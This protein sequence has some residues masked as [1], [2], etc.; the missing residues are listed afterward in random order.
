ML[1]FALAGSRGALMA[2]QAAA[3]TAAAAE[4]A[5]PLL[6]SALPARPRPPLHVARPPRP[7]GAAI[8]AAS[9]APSLP[10]MAARQPRPTVP[11]PFPGEGANA[12]LPAAPA[13]PPP[14][15][16][17]G[18]ALGA[19]RD[20]PPPRRSLDLAPARS[21]A[22]AVQAAPAFAS[23]PGAGARLHP[24]L[25][26]SFYARPGVGA[27]P[28]GPGLRNLG[29]SV[30][31][32]VGHCRFPALSRPFC[33]LTSAPSQC[34]LNAVLNLLSSLPPFGAALSALPAGCLA[35]GGVGD[36]LRA[37][38]AALDPARRPPGGSGAG[39]DALSDGPR[40]LQA[41]VLRCGAPFGR[42]TQEDAHELLL[43]LLGQTQAEVGA[44][45]GAPC[46]VT[47]WFGGA[48]ARTLVCE[49][50]GA[51][52]EAVAE[53]ILGLSLEVPEN[54]PRGRCD[55]PDLLRRALQ[56]E[57]RGVERRCEALAPQGAGAGAGAAGS[58]AAAPGAAPRCGGQRATLR[59]T[60][61][62]PPAALLLH[63]KRFTLRPAAPPRAGVVAS[64]S[65]VAVFSPPTLH[66]GPL[67]LLGAPSP[68]PPPHPVYDLVGVVSHTGPGAASG[69]YVCTVRGPGGAWA[70]HNDEAVTPVAGD[71][72]HNSWRAAQ[73]TYVLL[74]VRREGRGG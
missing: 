23:T 38:L 37:A 16:P 20:A 18:R 1:T 51:A 44:T 53:P 65:S 13:W 5:R 7:P 3:Q 8:A 4:H 42:G 19:G 63:L 34:Y 25:I 50:C 28:A 10:G 24:A 30:R 40:R 59:R 47:A 22:V 48:T 2:A 70:R 21:P 60:L 12:A 39:A 45:P 9:A 41:A 17:A 58:H 61:S 49:A 36:S 66:L 35:T 68:A 31:A 15:Q 69:H 33:R 64:K 74:Y 56:A 27:K 54:P 55:L 32:G 11:P 43:L 6:P 46:P 62:A 71:E 52:G 72:V 73:E 14:L 57:E 26:S 29:N 67:L